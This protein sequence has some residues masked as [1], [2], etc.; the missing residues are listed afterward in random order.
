[1]PKAATRGRVRRRRVAAAWVAAVVLAS[2]AF[3]AVLQIPMDVPDAAS[4]LTSNQLG[5]VN[6][7]S[8]VGQTFV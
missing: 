2:L 4:P 1:M 5:V 8:S 3:W 7:G 6:A